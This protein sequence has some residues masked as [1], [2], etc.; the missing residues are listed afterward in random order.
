MSTLKFLNRDD[1]T[2]VVHAGAVAFAVAAGV[3]VAFAEHNAVA[4]GVVA[5]A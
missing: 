3:V 4:I 1:T 2:V 5:H